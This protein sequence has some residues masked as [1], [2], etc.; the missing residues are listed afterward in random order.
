VSRRGG[1]VLAVAGALVLLPGVV[2]AK[3]PYADY[4]YVT[5]QPRSDAEVSQIWRLSEHVLSPHDPRLTPHTLAVTRAAVTRLRAQG[6]PLTVQPVDLQA[7]LDGAT[8][9]L[10]RNT[11]AALDEGQLGMFGEW[12]AQVKDLTAIYDYLDGLERTANGRAHVEVIG[13][14]FEGREIR[15]LRFAPAEPARASILVTGTQHARE[16]ASPMVAMGLADALVRQTSDPAVQRLL[17]HTE[18]VIVPVVNVDGYVVSHH[19]LRLQRKNLNILCGVDLNRNWD[20]EFGAGVPAHGCA[21]ENFPGQGPFSEPESQALRALASSLTNLRLYLDYHSPAEQVMIPFA[22]TRVRPPDYDKSRAWAEL[23][24]STVRELYGTLHPA[25]DGFDLAQGQGGGA[26]DWVRLNLA[27]SFAIELRDGR[28]LAGF[29]LPANQ[30]IPSIE[31]NWLAFRRLALEATDEA[32]PDQIVPAPH[33]TPPL[34]PTPA[35]TPSS[36]GCHVGGTT[37]AAA[38]APL[39]LVLVLALVSRRASRRGR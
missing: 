34:N 35:P 11:L 15:A 17:R 13:K 12:F 5:A 33:V 27:Q 30:I 36:A 16:W 32:A 10:P 28:E 29:E 3:G 8:A 37:P 24:A 7:A 2:H 1:H 26:I 25:R 19:G 18:V 4:V 38:P 6:I 20:V 21:E 39:V 14:S 23:Y 31:E 22:H 9:P